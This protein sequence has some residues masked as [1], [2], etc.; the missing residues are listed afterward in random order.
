MKTPQAPFM[1]RQSGAATL[2]V[3]MMLFLI[4]AMLAAFASRNMVYEQRI[5]GNYYRAGVAF[6][7]SEAGAEWTLA[8]LNADSV[9][10]NCAN[11]ASGTDFRSRY[12]SINQST[13]AISNVLPQQPVAACAYSGVNS[14]AC[15]CPADGTLSM[16]TQATNSGLQPMFSVMFGPGSRPGTAHVQVTGC[17]GVTDSCANLYT[18]AANALGRSDMS[19]DVAL[20]SAL[21]MPPVSPLVARGQVFAGS[22]AALGLINAAAGGSGQLVQTGYPLLAGDLA[23]AEGVPGSL[24]ADSMITDDA[25]LRGTAAEVFFASFFGMNSDHYRDQPKMRTVAVANCASGDCAGQL[26]TMITAGAQM[27]WL[28]RPATLATNL[29][30]GSASN[31]VII[32]VNG[33]LTITGPLRVYG[34]LYVRGN[35]SWSNDSGLPAFVSGSVAVEG[36]VTIS[37]S[38]NMAYDAN[39]MQILNNQRGSLVRVAGSWWDR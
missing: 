35:L 12:L 38:A 31:P 19:M 13:R 30:L 25:T 24:A 29:S 14:W 11:A 3:V 26:S 18:A 16:P 2:A 7:A 5:A 20:V 17:T 10:S 4:V 8:M 37:G 32:V 27:F 15:Q 21:K 34:L 28:D 22:P 39:A 6:E 33:D 23:Q 9:G 36:N 1:R